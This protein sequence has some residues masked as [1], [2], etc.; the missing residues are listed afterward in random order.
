MSDDIG[1]KALSVIEEV[2]SDV[3]NANRFIDK[4]NIHRLLYLC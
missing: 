2:T 3:E 4:V 1:L